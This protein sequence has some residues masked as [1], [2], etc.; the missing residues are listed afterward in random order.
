MFKSVLELHQRRIFR[1]LLV[2][3]N[4]QRELQNTKKFPS[5]KL[6]FFYPGTNFTSLIPKEPNNFQENI[7]VTPFF[8]CVSRWQLHKNVES[9]IYG[10][11]RFLEE[12]NLNYKLVLV[13][14]P[15]GFYTAPRELITSLKLEDA[16]WITQ[17]LS[18][19]EL[20]FLYQRAQI[21]LFLSVHEGFGLSVL[22]GM[23]CGCPA[24]V[25]KNTATYEV[26]GPGGVGV[27]ANNSSEIMEAIFEI[28][29]TKVHRELALA[30]SRKFNWT[31][32]VEKIMRIYS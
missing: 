27:D 29:N 7:G 17:D 31:N 11:A 4:A 8:V 25:S 20:K 2:S 16:I 15:V 5:E 14:K 30:Q 10:F 3:K 19:Q 32:S 18:D 6:D 22:E 21:N 28:I 23:A 9:S 12:T 13:G 26:I 24:I 1:I